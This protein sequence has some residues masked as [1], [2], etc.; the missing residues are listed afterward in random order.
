MSVTGNGNASESPAGTSASKVD[1]SQS[2]NIRNGN[3]TEG[4]SSDAE[5]ILRS[6]GYRNFDT[7][8]ADSFDYEETI[9]IYK[10]PDDEEYAEAIVDA[11]GH[12]EAIPD[13]GTYLFNSDY[14]VVIGA[15]WTL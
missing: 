6:M 15:D 13:D 1:S 8:N 2:I 4:L 5:R 11:L 9:V 10:D 12:G 14:L 7:G 3:G